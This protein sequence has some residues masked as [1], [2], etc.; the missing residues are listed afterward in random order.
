MSPKAKIKDKKLISTA[1]QQIDDAVFI[2]DINGKIMYVNNAFEKMTGYGVDEAIGKT[3]SI[4]NSDHHRPE[5][6]KDLWKTILSGKVFRKRIINKRKNGSLFHADHTITP[7]KNDEGEITHFVASWKDITEQIKEHQMRGELINLVSHELKTPLTTIKT[8]TQMLLRNAKKRNDQESKDFFER[9]DMQVNKLIKFIN[10]LLDVSNI[11]GGKLR[12]QF[13]KTDF[14]RLVKNVV[15]ESR[16]YLQT[17][18]IQLEGKSDTIVQADPHRLEQAINNLLTNACKFSPKDKPVIVQRKKENGAAV[19]LVK[20]QGRGISKK[21]Q[22]R[23]FS[24][25]YRVRSKENRSI[26]G[27]GLGLFI[28]SEIIKRHRGDIWVDSEPD[29]GSEFG[30]SV[31]A[32]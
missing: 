5:Y 18:S 21:E 19:L 22:K 24:R 2:T 10:D 28:T 27:V 12:Y 11:D 9:M 23:I 25:Y 13:Q 31:P 20:D 8:L 1:L 14:D 7:I 26:P 17:H 16:L 4:I 32:V 15:E 6:F 29:K 30:F 3:P